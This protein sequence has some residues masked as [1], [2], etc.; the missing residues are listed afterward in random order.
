MALVG[1]AKLNPNPDFWTTDNPP[2]RQV[3]IPAKKTYEVH[4]YASKVEEFSNQAAANQF[5]R[6]EGKPSLTVVPVKV[7]ERVERQVDPTYKSKPNVVVARVIQPNGKVV[8]HAVVFNEHDERAIRMAQ[9]IKS[10]DQ[11][12]LHRVLGWMAQIT[13]YFSSINTQYNPIFGMFNFTRDVQGAA[14]NLSN[15]D[16]AGK[17]TETLSCSTSMKMR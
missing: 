17:A 16:L 4:F 11:D 14:L 8:E 5:I 12:Q 15:T 2:K 7:P 13:R 9:S 1:S 10:L 6:Y 3:V